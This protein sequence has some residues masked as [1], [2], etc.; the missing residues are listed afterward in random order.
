MELGGVRCG[1]SMESGVH[2]TQHV[3]SFPKRDNSCG[4]GPEKVLLYS[5]SS[6]RVSFKLPIDEESAPVKLA[7]FKSKI[8]KYGKA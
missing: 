7:L 3:P 1:R 6:F 8:S 4:I 2:T 5:N